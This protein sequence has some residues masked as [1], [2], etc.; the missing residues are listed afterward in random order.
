M[1][2]INIKNLLMEVA[3]FGAI[4]YVTGG[5]LKKDTIDFAASDAAYQLIVGSWLEPALS[6]KLPGGAI[7]IKTVG[8]TAG[9]IVAEA[10][11]GRPIMESIKDVKGVV[12]KA[13]KVGGSVLAAGYATVAMIA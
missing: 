2:S 5:E 13:A 3:A 9:M 6:G 7:A 1:Q 8:V 4:D 12:M 11:R 10:I